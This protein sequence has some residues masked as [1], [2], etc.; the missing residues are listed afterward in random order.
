MFR[1]DPPAT[2]KRPH[3]TSLIPYRVCLGSSQPRRRR[4]R[5]QQDL[6]NG[7]WSAQ[8]ARQTTGTDGRSLACLCSVAILILWERRSKVRGIAK[9]GLVL[10]IAVGSWT[11]IRYRKS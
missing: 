8:T 3:V 4:D 2:G 6:A 5:C 7:P 9:S 11:R 10:G 1:E